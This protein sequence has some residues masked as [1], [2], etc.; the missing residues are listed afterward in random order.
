VF[1]FRLPG[2]ADGYRLWSGLA[3]FG[4]RDGLRDG[5]RFER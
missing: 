2:E 4:E 1:G 5:G 3:R